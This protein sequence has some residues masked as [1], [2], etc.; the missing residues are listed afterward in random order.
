MIKIIVSDS[1][2]KC[3]FCAEFLYTE[4]DYGSWEHMCVIG[5]D[6]PGTKQVLSYP[7][8]GTI[9]IP[10]GCQLRGDSIWVKL[11]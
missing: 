8:N 4:G 5:I 11:K 7:V 1:C 2:T 9:P 6:C 10:E 3:P